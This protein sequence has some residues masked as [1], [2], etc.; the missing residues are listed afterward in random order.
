[1]NR[2]YTFIE[3]ILIDLIEFKS[4]KEYKIALLVD[5]EKD[6]V[7]MAKSLGICALLV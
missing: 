4:M 5:D 1:M 6:N 7:E 2:F 3:Y